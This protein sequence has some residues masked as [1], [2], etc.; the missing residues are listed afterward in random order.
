MKILIEFIT[1]Y[2]YRKHPNVA[3]KC[4]K[5]HAAVEANI[6]YSN[7]GSI[8]LCDSCLKEIENKI[9]EEKLDHTMVIHQ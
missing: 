7:K 3:R 2:F 5:C 6:Y 8:Y 4:H 9:H 1:D